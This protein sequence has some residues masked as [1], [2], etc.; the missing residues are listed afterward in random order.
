MGTLGETS[1]GTGVSPGLESLVLSEIFGRC[2]GPWQAGP[3][4]PSFHCADKR[5]WPDHWNPQE[6]PGTEDVAGPTA[7]PIEAE[8]IVATDATVVSHVSRPK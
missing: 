8:E 4:Y 7:S 6:Y 2:N 3:W 1:T 5:G